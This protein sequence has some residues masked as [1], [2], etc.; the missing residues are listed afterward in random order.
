MIKTNAAQESSLT[1][2]LLPL[3]TQSLVKLPGSSFLLK[4]RQKILPALFWEVLFEDLAN[5]LG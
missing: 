4:E 1:T 2:L 5:G 3:A